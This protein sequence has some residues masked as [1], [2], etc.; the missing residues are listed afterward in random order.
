MCVHSYQQQSLS[1]ASSPVL[2]LFLSIFGFINIAKLKNP[3]Y[4]IKIL[5]FFSEESSQIAW[6]S[7]YSKEIRKMDINELMRRQWTHAKN[8]SHSLRRSSMG[9]GFD[10]PAEQAV[11]NVQRRASPLSF[12]F[13]YPVFLQLTQWMFVIENRRNHSWQPN[14]MCYVGSSIYKCVLVFVYWKLEYIWILCFISPIMPCVSFIVSK[15]IRDTNLHCWFHWELSILGALISIQRWDFV[16][17]NFISVGT[18]S[19]SQMKKIFS[20]FLNCLTFPRSNLY[21][22]WPWRRI[23]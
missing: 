11:L 8:Q 23:S 2:M 18:E 7:H 15:R 6:R 16:R 13:C 14:F 17:F 22:P 1:P 3:R 21:S 12:N 4:S 19:H 10:R 9:G 5:I 20:I